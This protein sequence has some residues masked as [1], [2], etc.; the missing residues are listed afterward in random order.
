MRISELVEI[1]N[2]FPSDLIICCKDKKSNQFKEALLNFHTVQDGQYL[3]IQTL[4]TN[5]TKEI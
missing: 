3:Y 2:A 1:L 5:K 4:P